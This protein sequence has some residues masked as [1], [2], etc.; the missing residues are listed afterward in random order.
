MATMRFAFRT[1]NYCHVTLFLRKTAA[2]SIFKW[3]T[4]QIFWR[5]HL[6]QYSQP[7]KG[8]VNLSS[9]YLMCPVFV[10]NTNKYRYQ[11]ICCSLILRYIATNLEIWKWPK[12]H[13]RSVLLL[14]STL[15]TRRG[16]K[17]QLHLVVPLM[18]KYEKPAVAETWSLYC[19]F[20]A[21]LIG[22]LAKVHC[23]ILYSVIKVCSLI[24]N[25]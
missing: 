9:H 1:G 15:N 12:G 5:M 10:N 8:Y 14:L 17:N 21:V 25:K 3:L 4:S 16:R 6:N 2:S 13:S 20:C 22:K 18:C 24:P 19:F 23:L 11:G 7:Y